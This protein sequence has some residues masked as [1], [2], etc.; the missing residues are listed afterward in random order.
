M[1]S[2]PKTYALSIKLSLIFREKTVIVSLCV[3]QG[4]SPFNVVL[5][6][7]NGFRESLKLIFHEV[8]RSIYSLSSFDI[9]SAMNAPCSHNRCLLCIG[10]DVKYYSN[11]IVDIW[12]IRVEQ[13]TESNGKRDHWL[14]S[15]CGFGLQCNSYLQSVLLLIYL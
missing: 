9:C 3:F 12:T 5:I 14:N 1:S 13:K 6:L 15:I 7:Y 10:M 2:P 11:K 4:I 8:K